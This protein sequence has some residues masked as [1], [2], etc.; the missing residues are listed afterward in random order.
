MFFLAAKCVCHHVG[1]PWMVLNV[2]IVVLHKF[3]PSSLPEVQ[4]F[5]GEDILQTLVVDEDIAGDSV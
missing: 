3:E 2:E 4:L 5:L 1:L